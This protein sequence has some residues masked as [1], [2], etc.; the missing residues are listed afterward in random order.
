LSTEVSLQILEMLDRDSLSVA[1]ADRNSWRKLILAMNGT[2]YLL[3]F[4]EFLNQSEDEDVRS[5]CC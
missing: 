3:Q 4:K 2:K 5:T 1:I